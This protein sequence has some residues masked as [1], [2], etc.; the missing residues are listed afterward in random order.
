MRL[1]RLLRTG[2]RALDPLLDVNPG[3]RAIRA[4]VIRLGRAHLPEH[5]LADLH[6]RFE[7][8][9]L[10]AVRAGMSRAPLD[11]VQLGAG[12]QLQRLAWLPSDILDAQ[13]AGNVIR[14]LAQRL[15]EIGP[16]Q[17]VLVAR[18]QV[19]ERIEHG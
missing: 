19:L 3:E 10:D 2:L 1:A 6:R 13:M 16:Q 15:L 14:H 9:L 17:A 4:D 11:R 7:R 18:D 8:L 5:R 12:Y